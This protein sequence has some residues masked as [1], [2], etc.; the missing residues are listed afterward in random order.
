MRIGIPKEIVANENRVALVPESVGRLVKSGNEILVEHDAGLQA[1]FTDEAYT[2]VGATI[3][4]DAAALYGGSDLVCK[5]QRP[6]VN[7]ATGTSEIALM[8]PGT[9]LIALLQPLVNHELVRE[10]AG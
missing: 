2:K 3:A 1:S 9:A 10:L 7:E 8:H 5:V 4:P 6:V